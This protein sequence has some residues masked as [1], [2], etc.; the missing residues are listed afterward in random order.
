LEDISNESIGKEFGY[1]KNYVSGLLKQ[2]TG[3]PLHRY[4]LHLRLMHAVQLIENTDLTV[5]E[6]ADASGFYDV[7]YFSSYFKKHFGVTPTKYRMG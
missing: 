4:V 1:H 5:S 7:A 2:M 3:I 6:I